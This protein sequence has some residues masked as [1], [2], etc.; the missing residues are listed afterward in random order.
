[1]R[2]VALRAPWYKGYWAGGS[3]M[4]G[5]D[6]MEHAITYWV[7]WQT[8]HSPILAGL[9][10]LTHWLPH[11]F[12]SIPLGGLADRFDCRRLVQVSGL[13]FI[14]ASVGWGVLF[15]TNSLQPWECVALLLVHGFASAIWKAP[16]QLM[17]YDMV[18]P[19]GVPSAVR[20]MATGLTLGQLVGPAIGALLLTTVGPTV[21]IFLNVLMYLPFITYLFITP[22]TGH[23]RDAGRRAAAHWSDIISVLRD[24]P[25]Y[26]AILIVMILQGAVALFIGAAL[27]PLLPEFGGTLGVPDG[28][29]YAVLISSMAAGA[30]VSGITLEAIGR[31]RASVRVV[32]TTAIAY[33]LSILVFAFSHSYALSIV[34][35]FVAGAGSLITS[36]TS[37]TIVQLTAPPERRG[38]F[39]GAAGMTS[40]GFQAGSGILMGL[41]AGALGVS[42]AVAFGAVGIL[43]VAAALLVVVL[44]RGRRMPAPVTATIQVVDTASNPVVE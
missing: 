44:A 21:A 6:N 15:A 14:T 7:M 1:M 20:L 37:T 17:L 3:L 36:S 2:F 32:I 41:L 19:E 12:F 22:M 24:V 35:L 23:V 10:V 42:G 4:M 40:N 29:G 27:M 8:F 30:L 25:K 18:G 28:A 26:P 33:A 38:R 39:V 9:A 34:A 31:I 5:G 13:L 16:D 43:V 11:L